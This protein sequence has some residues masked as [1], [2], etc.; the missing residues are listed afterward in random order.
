[1]DRR[2]KIF[3]CRRNGNAERLGIG[4]RIYPM[5]QS[6]LLL[7]CLDGGLF[8][9]IPFGR[10]AHFFLFVPLQHFQIIVKRQGLVLAGFPVIDGDI[11]QRLPQAAVKGHAENPPEPSFPGLFVISQKKSHS[12]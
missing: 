12:V 4:M 1:F 5:I 10:H 9:L 2:Y 6:V 3:I 11:L 8:G 7:K